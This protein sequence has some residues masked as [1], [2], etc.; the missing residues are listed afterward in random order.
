[1]G[2]VQGSRLVSIKDE[3]ARLLEEVRTIQVKNET[4]EVTSVWV[5]FEATATPGS[6]TTGRYA[7]SWDIS[8]MIR[9]Y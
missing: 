6:M 8:R 4:L 9:L 1:M 7:A 2:G 5:A 3:H